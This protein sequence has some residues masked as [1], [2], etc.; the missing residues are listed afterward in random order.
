MGCR[1]RN[2]SLNE[3]EKCPIILPTKS[4]L[5]KLLI[6]YYHDV[7]LHGSI[8]LILIH[9]R[10]M[11]WVL[12]LKERIKIFVNNCVKC[13]RYKAV[14]MQQKMADFPSVHVRIAR[15]FSRVGMDYARP[16]VLEASKFRGQKMF[17][18]YI[19]VFVCMDTKA[20]H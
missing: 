16:V 12:R 1:L 10:K 7:T 13:K 18:D 17:K 6:S 4:H 8:Q 11:F 20:A 15:P 19:I 2:S 3:Y 14:I 9:I 5:V